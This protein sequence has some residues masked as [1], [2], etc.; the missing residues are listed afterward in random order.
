[1]TESEE[2]Y[3]LDIRSR[4]N[5]PKG[6]VSIVEEIKNNKD[7]IH[8]TANPAP[9]SQSYAVVEYK[10]GKYEVVLYN[11][12][13][14]KKVL[15]RTGVKTNENEVNP[16]YPLLA[17]DGKGSRLACIYWE[18]GKVK[19]FVYDMVARFKRIKQTISHFEQVQDMKY[20][21]NPNN[22]LL[23]AVRKGQSDIFVYD[24]EKDTFEQVTN[25]SYADLD[26]TF[27]SFPNKS[28][29]IFSSNRPNPNV[30]GK[31][32]GMPANKFNIF[33]ADNYNR[34]EFRQI[35]QLTNM[36]YG[37][38]RYPAPYNVQHFTF[39]SDE[40]GVANRYA[41]FLQPSVQVLIQYM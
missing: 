11:N 31:D 1:M 19:L 2:K 40:N 7:F 25:D 10:K 22:L 37:N 12:L 39:V 18:E 35:T 41:G 27:V 14:D 30:V 23:S 29:I 38:A 6:T 17:W 34:S 15:L 8:F 16:N 9:R 20:M 32:T 36:K 13:V 21:V 4:K 24:I 33:L 26:A 3:Y 5:I 28:G